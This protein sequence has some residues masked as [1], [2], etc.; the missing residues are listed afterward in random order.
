MGSLNFWIKIYLWT[1][2]WI[3]RASIVTQIKGNIDHLRVIERVRVRIRRKSRCK[4][5]IASRVADQGTT[6]G[7]IK[8]R[9]VDLS[10][11]IVLFDRLF[12]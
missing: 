2:A 11:R 6:V 3:S 9:R 10:E 4:N 1:C 12:T 5:H 8:G 7:D